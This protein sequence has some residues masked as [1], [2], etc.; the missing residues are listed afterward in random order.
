MSEYFKTQVSCDSAV[1]L[2][3]KHYILRSVKNYKTY[4]ASVLLCYKSKP[5]FFLFLLSYFP[6]IEFK[7]AIGMQAVRMVW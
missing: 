4:S 3:Q 5:F 6:K 1:S 7:F 2:I